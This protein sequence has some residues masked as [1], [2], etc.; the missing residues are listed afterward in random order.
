MI[1]RRRSWNID[2]QHLLTLIKVHKQSKS[3]HLWRVRRFNEMLAWC[4]V[5]PFP[6]STQ[7]HTIRFQWTRK[8]YSLYI[9]RKIN[10]SR[11]VAADGTR[12]T[13]ANLAATLS[14][15]ELLLSAI[16][17]EGQGWWQVVTAG[18]KSMYI[19]HLINF[20][21]AAISDILIVAHVRYS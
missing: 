16:N 19:R 8:K 18:G 7:S 17:R 20:Y 15:R 13:R 21:S 14:V 11:D 2:E 6:Y 1:F 10:I 3:C 12:T 5:R 4:T 9:K